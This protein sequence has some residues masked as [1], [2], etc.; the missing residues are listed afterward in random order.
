LVIAGEEVTTRHGHWLAVGLP[1]SGWVDW[2]YAP[3]DGVFGRYAAQVRLGGGSPS[4]APHQRVGLPQ[5]VVHAAELSTPA[6]V[7]GLRRGRSCLAESCATTLELTASCPVGD[8]TLA[9][10]PG[11]TLVMPPGTPATVSAEDHFARI[12]VRRRTR[13]RF[14]SMVALTNPVWLKALDPSA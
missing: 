3:R 1:P 6:L 10:G 11:E 7:D 9:A 14:A 12:E 2:R 8:D 4:H 13:G 5:T